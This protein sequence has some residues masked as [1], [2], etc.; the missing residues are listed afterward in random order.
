M[1]IK[2]KSHVSNAERTE[3]I[4][5]KY[6]I[7]LSSLSVMVS[8]KNKTRQVMQ[9]GGLLLEFYFLREQ[10]YSWLNINR[11]TSWLI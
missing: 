6:F 7:H 9:T 10:K 5:C 4:C 8:N 1:N 2:D 11:V 3:G